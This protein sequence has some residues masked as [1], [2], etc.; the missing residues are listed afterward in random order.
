MIPLAVLDILADDWM[1]SRQYSA[2][3]YG[4]RPSRIV[5]W[6]AAIR[7]RSADCAPA[8]AAAAATAVTPP[9]RKAA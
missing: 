7:G 8:P 1:R 2:R 4:T 5:G 3:K 6:L 9:H